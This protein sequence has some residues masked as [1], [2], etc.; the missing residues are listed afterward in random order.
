VKRVLVVEDDAVMA[1]TLQSGFEFNGYSVTLARDGL[2]GL[3]LASE[4]NAD[5]V[6]LDVMLP[7]M[8]GID[9]C[10]RLRSQGNSIPIIMLTARG[11][12][13]DKVV[14]FKSG[15]DDYLTKPFS[16]LEL[17]ARVEALMRRCSK[18]VAAPEG[19]EFGDV[20]IDFEKYEATKGGEPLAL[21]YR[22]FE[23]LKY[24]IAHRGAVV[25]RDEL[26]RAIWGTPSATVTRT[27]DVHMAK[28]RKKIKGPEGGRDYILTVPGGGYK[29]IA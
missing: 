25:T 23:I 14:G 12:E 29:F 9:V 15:A 4:G 17:M 18:E 6:V 26:L 24:F 5:L 28:L 16:F 27:V 13:I 19:Y 3:Q 2:T 7:N 11:Q 22:E 20:S 1:M 21:S 8:S 10:K